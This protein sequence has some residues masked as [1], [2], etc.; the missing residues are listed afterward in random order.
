MTRMINIKRFLIAFLIIDG[1]LILFSFY[2]GNHWLVSSQ[3]A[4]FASLCV[5]L[6]S[7]LGYKKM[8][9]K[10]IAVG[11]IPK[12]DRDDI[13][14]LED[15]HDLYADEVDFKEVIKE[16][17]AKITDFKTTALNLGKSAGGAFSVFRLLA[18][19]VLF[20]SFLYLNRHD[21]LNIAAYLV[22]LAIVPLVAL[23]LLFF[24]KE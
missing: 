2:Q 16:E 22:G 14:I 8:I 5:T 4:F 21:M 18:Y 23:I 12:E 10:K 20:L 1:A 17:R 19:L 6:S 11:D 13:E 9:E 24:N 15:R 7:F 3:S